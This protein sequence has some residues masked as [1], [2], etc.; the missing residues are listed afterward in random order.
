[1]AE[2]ME[3]R[4][5]RLDPALPAYLKLGQKPAALAPLEAAWVGAMRQLVSFLY[6]QSFKDSKMANNLTLLDLPNLLCYEDLLAEQD[7]NYTWPQFPETTASSLCYTSGTTG[8]PKGVLYS[9]RSTV[10][11]SLSACTVD[12]APRSSAQNDGSTT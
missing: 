7:S 9:H 8:H 5:L 12:G 2:M 11:H 6:Q 10:L 1:M 4:Y 3:Y